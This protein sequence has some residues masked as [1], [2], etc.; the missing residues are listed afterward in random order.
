[1]LLH[2]L[3]SSRR[4]E[5]TSTPDLCLTIFKRGPEEYRTTLNIDFCSRSETYHR[6]DS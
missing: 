2:F 5:Y 6:A 3:P 1:M 4:V